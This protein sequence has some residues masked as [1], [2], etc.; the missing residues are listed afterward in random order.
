MKR[1]VSFITVFALLLTACSGEDGQDGQ[2][3]G[4]LVSSAFEIELDFNAIDNY[5]V[6]E[7]YGFD[8]FPFDVT[9]VYILWDTV[10]GQ[11]IWRLLPQSINFDDGSELTYNFDYTLTDVRF[12]LDGN[13][14]FN[15]LAPIWTQNQVFRVVVVPADNVGKTNV[16]HSNLEAVMALYNINT[17]TKR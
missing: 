8:L 11:D 14:N 15:T 17:F 5:E 10:D 13:T 9:L 12:F 2:D 1:I 4:L 6:I 7:P 3:G 16:D